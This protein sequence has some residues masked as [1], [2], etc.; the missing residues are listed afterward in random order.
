MR[1]SNRIAYFYSVADDLRTTGERRTAPAFWRESTHDS[2][3]GADFVQKWI[4]RIGLL[5]ADARP[6]PYRRKPYRTRLQAGSPLPPLRGPILLMR[7]L[8]HQL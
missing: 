3:R 1:I 7:G 2:D 5:L 4:L 8:R 6:P